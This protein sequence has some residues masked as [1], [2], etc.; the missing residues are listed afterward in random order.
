MVRARTSP[1]SG[2][3]I[4]SEMSSMPM[5]RIFMTNQ[6]QEQLKELLL[7]LHTKDTDDPS[8]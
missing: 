3:G 6:N 7:D 4:R 1:K 2:D 8:E 5:Q